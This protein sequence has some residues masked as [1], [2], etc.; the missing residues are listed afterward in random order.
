MLRVVR[1]GFAIPTLL[2]ALSFGVSAFAQ[3]GEPAGSAA[4]AE[5]AV[6]RHVF[7]YLAPA[8]VPRF[9]RPPRRYTPPDGFAGHKWGDLRS[10]FTRLPEQPAAVRAAWTH[11]KRVGNEVVCTGRD[12][13]ACTVQDYLNSQRTWLFEGDGFHVLSE[14]MIESQGFRFPQSGVLIHPVVY[15]FCA[16]WHG[17]RNR[18]PEKFEKMNRL[19][20]M[21]LL[22]ET[23]SLGELR[24]LPEDHV[25]QY[26]LVLSE[27]TSL[28]GKPANFTWRGHVTVETVAGPAVFTPSVDRKFKTWR[29]CPA[30]PDGLMTRCEASIVLSIDPDV[31]R[32]IV[33][34]STPAMWQ[35]AFAR[36]SSEDAAPDALYTLMHAL[37]FKHRY[38][39]AKRK[40][41]AWKAAEAKKAKR[42][43]AEEP[44]L[45]DAKSA[46]AP[47]QSNSVSTSKQGSM[48]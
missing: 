42:E 33:L 39:L 43:K 28:Y 3:V 1:A 12:V 17:K 34:F 20:G 27:L 47:G 18:V 46:E 15:E 5:D 19:C 11:G 29:W 38:A 36:E 25:T 37:S 7:P 10:T 45:P 30:P 9:P 48:P 8:N 22:F 14:Y 26:D 35:Y 32:G 16:N 31:G 13:Q 4:S 41:A 2:L 6:A 21:R 23:E 40:E 44:G 24:K